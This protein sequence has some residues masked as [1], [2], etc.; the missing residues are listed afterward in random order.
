[1]IKIKQRAQVMLIGMA[2]LI[3]F[4]GLVIWHDRPSQKI[5]LYEA[6]TMTRTFNQ[7]NPDFSI[8]LKQLKP[9]DRSVGFYLVGLANQINWPR[10]LAQACYSDPVL[11]NTAASRIREHYS[12]KAETIRYRSLNDLLLLLQAKEIEAP[13]YISSL[14]MK[15]YMLVSETPYAISI[16]SIIAVLIA[17]SGL[18]IVGNL[19]KSR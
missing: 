10:S 19:P 1:M 13:G 2:V 17:V 5:T 16:K 6:Q 9:A 12:E 14:N 11:V 3:L 7:L 8:L 4:S 15:S 18:I